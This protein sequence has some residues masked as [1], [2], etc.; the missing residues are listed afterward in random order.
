LQQRL[1][2]KRTTANFPSYCRAFTPAQLK[3]P[4]V[5]KQLLANGEAAADVRNTIEAAVPNFAAVIPFLHKAFAP[6]E[7][8]A[9]RGRKAL[10][11]FIINKIV[12][13]S[14]QTVFTMFSHDPKIRKAPEYDE[15]INS[16]TFRFAMCATLLASDWAARGG[17]R[18][19][20][21]ATIRNDLIDSH[22]ATCATYFD[23]FLSDDNKSQWIYRRAA[24]ILALMRTM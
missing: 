10:S 11:R 5:Q 23:G 18:D 16:Y 2:D 8:A 6:D 14:M 4:G 19:A 3:R 15:L 24:D 22:I 1:I 12:A 7:R 9:I 20:K 17:A 13:E 21:A